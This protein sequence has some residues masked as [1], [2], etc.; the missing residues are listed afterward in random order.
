MAAHDTG[1]TLDS[2]T[3]TKWS[4]ACLECGHEQG[5]HIDRADSPPG[6]EPLR[7]VQVH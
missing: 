2:V 3:S 1:A 4:E 6:V 5:H 7:V